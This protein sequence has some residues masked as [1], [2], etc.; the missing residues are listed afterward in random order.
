M[1]RLVQEGQ[2]AL[3]TPA[4]SGFHNTS[5]IATVTGTDVYEHRAVLD[6][7]LDSGSYR[8]LDVRAEAVQRPPF[9]RHLSDAGLASTVMSIYSSPYVPGLLGTQVQGWGAIDPYTA[10][11]DVETFDPPEVEQLLGRVVP[12]RQRLYRT[13]VPRTAAEFR[14]YRDRLLEGVKE[15]TAGLRAL[16]QE[17][18][19]DFFFGSYGEPH[20]GGHLLWHLSD[21]EHP[22][23]D[24]AFSE[25]VG[26]TVTAVYRAVDAGIGELLELVPAETRCFVI[27]PHGMAPSYVYE[28]G[29]QVLEAAGLLVPRTSGS[30]GSLR[31]RVL[32]AGWSA[33]RRVVPTSVRLAARRRLPED[34]LV[35]SMPLAHVDWAQTRVFALPSDMTSYLRV[36]LKGREPEGIV[37]RGDYTRVCDEVE[38]LFAS[39]RHS[40]T[41]RPAVDRIARCDRELGGP[42]DD[43]LPD[44]CVVWA[45][46]E[47]VRSLDLPGGGSVELRFEDPRTGQHRHLGFLVGVGPGIT[48]SGSSSLGT[49]GGSLLDV[50][51]TALALLGVDPSVL[52]GR[53]LEAFVA[54]DPRVSVA[55]GEA[56][57]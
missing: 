8:I 43:A 17:T 41:Q 35:A 48:A 57:G 15:Q 33:G 2:S 1:G 42:S 34:G 44:I 13:V 12:S 54:A 29:E 22:S 39:L 18:R 30:G 21:P 7:Q 23:Y 52:P 38:Q 45:D 32:R 16:L 3:L 40:E 31:G 9:W 28:P 25:E 56:E 11:F 36:N 50:G 14:A 6:R 37:P 4:P 47:P 20:H 53:P 51:P 24:A 55:E 5:W 10:K 49:V 26:E 27:T 19:W 46:E